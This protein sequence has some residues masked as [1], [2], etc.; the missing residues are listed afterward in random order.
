MS[1]TNP[2]L[3]EGPVTMFKPPQ[4]RHRVGLLYADPNASPGIVYVLNPESLKNPIDPSIDHELV[5]SLTRIALRWPRRSIV[6][7]LWLPDPRRWPKTTRMFKDRFGARG[8][9]W[10]GMED[11]LTR[12]LADVKD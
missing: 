8:I 9:G 7:F 4:H 12:R 11:E 2:I 10:E 3:P 1:M 6:F 5:E